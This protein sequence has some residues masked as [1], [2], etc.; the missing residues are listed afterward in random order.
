MRFDKVFKLK[1][2]F[3]IMNKWLKKE[4]TEIKK[5]LKLIFTSKIFYIS[6]IIFYIGVL[7]NQISQSILNKWRIEGVV[8]P[9]LS[10][11]ILDNIPYWNISFIYD[12][13]AFLVIIVFASYVVYKREYRKIPYFLLLLGSFEILRGI[14]IILTPLGNPPGFEGSNSIFKGFSKYELGVYPSGHSGGT[15]LYILMSKG[16]YKYI[17]M[18]L[19]FI[20]IAA[21]FFSRGHYTI[22]VLSGLIFAYAIFCFMNKYLK[23][24][25]IIKNK[26]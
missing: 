13:A 17:L 2:P 24:K 14:F 3:L 4:L 10:D 9:K 12:W 25:F 23:N 18:A 26:Y 8:Y 22:D 20:L 19:L 1:F 7:A 15:F 16:I 5:G 21:L 6:F 11:I